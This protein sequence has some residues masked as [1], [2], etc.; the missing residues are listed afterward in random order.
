MPLISI[1]KNTFFILKE[2]LI[3]EY[4]DKDQLLI[5]EQYYLDRLKPE[6]NILQQAGSSLGY[7]HSEET[8]AKIALAL[9]GEKHPNFGKKHSDETT[10]RVVSGPRG[11]E[12][13][14][15]MSEKKIRKTKT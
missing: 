7:K 10:L 13:L 11:P 3:F 1:I 4:C 5:R 9:K 2:Y 8:R 15:K 6:Y 14:K 12:T